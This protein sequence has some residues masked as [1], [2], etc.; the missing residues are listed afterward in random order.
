MSFLS[1][2]LFSAPDLG[3]FPVPFVAPLVPEVS[4][5]LPLYL[6]VLQENKSTVANTIKIILYCSRVFIIAPFKFL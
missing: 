2:Y 1:F 4:A 6:L 5:A 3:I